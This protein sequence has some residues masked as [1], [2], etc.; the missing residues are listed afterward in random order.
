MT[1]RP[2]AYQPDETPVAARL[3]TGGEPGMAG[4]DS[5]LAPMWEL[6]RRL[7]AY[8]RLTS[9]LVRDPA[10]PPVAKA[11]LVVGGAYLVSPIDLI[12]GIIPVAGQIDDLYVVLTGLQQAIRL[13]P[14]AVVDAHFGAVGLTPGIV[15]DDLAAIR[16]VVRHGIVSTLRY[17]GALMIRGT[18][19]AKALAQWAGQRGATINDNDSFGPG[20]G[21]G[22]SPARRESRPWRRGP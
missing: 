20:P 9:A 6:I 4:E 10:V 3:E 14:P 15:D 12:P 1:D 18:R 13:S 7:P 11:C 22:S 2:D 8:A 5:L 21:A 16:K 19:R 17:G